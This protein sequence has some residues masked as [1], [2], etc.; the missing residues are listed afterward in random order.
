MIRIKDKEQGFIMP[1]LIAFMAIIAILGTVVIMISFQAFRNSKRQEHTL[2]AQLASTAGLD[3][4]KEQYELDINYTGSVETS[5][6]N[7]SDISATFEVEHLGFTNAA[8]TQQDVK[9][10]GRVYEDGETEPFVE[11]VVLGKL[12][13]DAGSS[14]S[15]RFIF[16]IDNS[17]SMSIQ[18]WL[19]SKETVDL[20]IEY[21]LDNTATAQIAVVQ[22]GTNNYSQEHKY[23]VTVPFTRDRSTAVN[24]DR[25]YGWGSVSPN[26]FQDHLAAS[27]AR[28]R[29]ES[30]YGPGD[31]LDLAGSSS[32]QYVLFT[33][34]WGMD[35]SGCCSALKK[36]SGEDFDTT[37]NG[38]FTTKDQHGE[39]NDL[40]DGT[41]F[42]EHGYPD[43]NA[44][45]TVLNINTATTRETIETSAAI[46][47]PGGAWTGDV[48]ENPDD[49]E[50]EGVLPRRYISSSLLQTDPEDILSILDE[51]ITA[52]LI[53]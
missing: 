43:L 51:I 30:V 6:L 22:Y 41:V 3:F 39:F 47:S 37:N 21:V 44:Q 23:D 38:D 26:D 8:N 19:D 2:T 15:T 35:F 42:D 14:A 24:W 40:K 48:D 4:A 31:E 18:D 25:R 12:T 53:F 45:F 10:Y 52:E 7:N 5:F 1:T 33:D 50:G 28:M 49:P 13:R 29:D 11:R 17:G 46:A 9:V 16:I 27:L 34:A 36:Y 32:V 20:A